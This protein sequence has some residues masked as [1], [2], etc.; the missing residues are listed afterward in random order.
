MDDPFFKLRPFGKTPDDEICKC[1]PCNELALCSSLG[2]NPLRCL[3]C[4]GEVEPEKIGFDTDVA[5]QISEWNTIWQ[6]LSNLWLDSGDYESW[7]IEQLNDPK[8]S[9]NIRGLAIV[10]QLN[11][12]VETY[13]WWFQDSEADDYQLADKCPVCF[14]S[15]SQNKE[16]GYGKCERCSVLFWC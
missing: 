8:G 10:R 16:R 7:A 12:F 14:D 15:L 4:R 3:V 11:H 1:D 2:P 6:S 13:Y 5:E 9:V